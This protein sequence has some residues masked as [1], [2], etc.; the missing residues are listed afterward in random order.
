VGADRAAVGVIP[1]IVA[2]SSATA[3][4]PG[5]TEDFS[6]YSTGATITDDTAGTNYAFGS[7]FPGPDGDSGPS[8]PS[9]KFAVNTGKLVESGG[10]GYSGPVPSGN[11]FFWRVHTVP[12]REAADQY[13][14]FRCKLGAFD[15]VGSAASGDAFDAWLGYQNQWKL[16]ALQIIRRGGGSETKGAQIYLKHKVPFGAASS[17][18]FAGNGGTAG[19]VANDGIYYYVKTEAA[20]GPVSN[21]DTFAPTYAGAGLSNMADNGTSYDFVL[22][23]EDAGSGDVRIQAWRD[24]TL[25]ASWLDDGDRSA[26]PATVDL[27]TKESLNFNRTS[28]DFAS[29]AGY[30]VNNY[31]PITQTGRVGWRSDNLPVYVDNIDFHPL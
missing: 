18:G 29:T 4:G 20:T 13:F 15:T 21:R 14:A 22:T 16:Y 30:D 26:S 7:G 28:G 23:K 9:D 8:N 5:F 31:F 2:S 10:W 3:A 19:N 1:G 17:P 11:K 27:T 24:S 12:G 25:V 6:G